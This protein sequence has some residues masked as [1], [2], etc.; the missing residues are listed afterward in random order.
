MAI[1]SCKF[2]SNLVLKSHPNVIRM[3]DTTFLATW[4]DT[5]NVG[6]VHLTKAELKKFTTSTGSGKGEHFDIEKKTF[7]IGIVRTVRIQTRN[8]NG[9]GQPCVQIETE[10]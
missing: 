6:V 8:A 5:G 4:D 9:N 7:F 3:D 1:S 10:V 2:L